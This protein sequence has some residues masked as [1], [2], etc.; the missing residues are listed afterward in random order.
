[1]FSVLADP[2]ILFFFLGVAAILVKS[3]LE[4]PQPIPKFLSIYLLF[5]IGFKGGA[6]LSHSQITT[7]II[8]TLVCAVLLAALI[9]WLCFQVL[10]LK[11]DVYNS[12]AIAAAYGSVSAVTY[13]TAQ[14]YLEFKSISFG[15]HMVA[16]MALME[17]P[18]ILVGIYLAQKYSTESSATEESVKK[19]KWS[20]LIKEAFTNGSVL[21]ILGAFLIGLISGEK[22]SL[23]LKPFVGDIFKGMLCLFLLDMGIV[24]S[25]RITDL[26]K[27]GLFLISF[28]IF[29]ALMNGLIGLSMAYALGLNQGDS[30][31]FVILCGSA[32]YIAV[33]AAMRLAIPK[34]NPSLYVSMSLAITF[35]FNIIV[36]L[37][38]YSK[39]IEQIWKS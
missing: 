26:R 2:A 15:G 9:P 23:A 18:A 17:S 32:S 3:D 33:P 27:A 31:L 1:M 19:L 4:I 25:R 35:P 14:S 29:G 24:A 5:A 20:H 12:A 21:L 38:L 39:L 36:G 34:A 10:R 8:L 11:L 7:Q 37:P 13:A 30:L 16:A 22:G 28:A 6:E